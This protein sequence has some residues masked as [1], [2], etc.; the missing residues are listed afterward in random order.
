[1]SSKASCIT[2]KRVY[3]RTCSGT[4]SLNSLLQEVRI[5]ILKSTD[6]ENA[7]VPAVT[8][9]IVVSSS[10]GLAPV[11]NPFKRLNIHFS[12]CHD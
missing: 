4:F 10:Q 2:F 3:L 5:C 8:I 12:N 9:Q 1:M 6:R 7:L 11:Y